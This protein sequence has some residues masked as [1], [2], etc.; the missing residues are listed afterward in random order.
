LKNTRR[1][2]SKKVFTPTGS[3]K[4]FTLIEL[5]IALVLLVILSGALYGTFFSVVRGSGAVREQTEPLRDVRVTLD[6]LRR[7]LSATYF[8]K[9]NERL[10]FVVEDRDVF[11]KPAS[12][13]DFS[14]YTVPRRGNVPSSDI[15]EAR[16]EPVE[17]EGNQIIL[18]RRTRDIFLDV[19]PVSYP[20]TGRIEGFLVE[21][22][23]GTSWVKSW[24][25]ALNGSLPKA[26]RI[27]VLLPGIEKPTP[28]TAVIVPRVGGA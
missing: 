3:E 17:K 24:D 19:K 25:T 11:G 28:F 16:Y 13:L 23:D 8:I 9:G 1:R 12:V 21:C 20:L 22:Y 27:T 14:A 10:H 7:E 2:S 15:M 5:L 6:M 26:V 18:S 4:G